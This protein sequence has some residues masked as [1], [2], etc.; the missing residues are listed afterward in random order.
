[1]ASDSL[2][3][4]PTTKNKDFQTDLAAPVLA[5]HFVHDIYTSMVPP[6]LPVLID[7]L[8]LN[9]TLAGSLSAIMQLPG[10]LNPLIGYVA[11]KV[12][13]RYFIILAPAVTA[14]LVS[15]IGLA[16]GY[17]TIAILLFAAGVSTAM[18]HAPAP[19][20]VARASGRRV[21]LGM[22][23]F[24]AT[25]ELG[26]A[27]GP[28]LAVW[29]V[30]TWSLEG[31]WR[32]MFLGWAVSLL[33]FWRLNR[34]KPQ[35]E[36]PGSLQAMLPGIWRVFIPIIF[37]NLFRNP[38]IEALTTYLPTYM[39]LQGAN[40]WIA[41]SSLAIVELSGVPGA[42]L[43]GVYSDRLGRKRIL[44][45]AVVAAA[46]LMLVFLRVN[47][48]LQGL[49]LMALG[50]TV[51]ATMPV[52]QAIVQEQFPNNRAVANGLFMMVTFV[53]RPLGTFLVGALGDWLGLPT[54]YLIAALVSLLILPAVWA[55]PKT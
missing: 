9:L 37:F 28:L 3:L 19:A 38:L 13:V 40:L 22:S 39:N 31:M 54:A 8:S 45:A 21:G 53:L 35:M 30:T 20:M 36:K 50:F 41:G 46:L 17:W 12:S 33:L 47:G 27:V 23:L 48:W 32:L 49:L 2:P 6:L 25:G 42:L 55:L 16:P 11:D 15:L 34:L 18:F 10:L 43:M 29:A 1:M 4:T 26:Y 51:F 52:I 44:S 14:T 24:M 7:K 5:G